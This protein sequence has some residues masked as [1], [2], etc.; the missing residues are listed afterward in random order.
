LAIELHILGS[1]SAAFAHNRH[2]TSQLLRIQEKYFL[3]DCGE[4]TQ[5]LLK[6]YKIKLSRI[7]FILIS[8]LHGDHYY[9]LIGLLSTIHLYGRTTELKIIGPPGL[10]DI[11]SLQLKYSET[12]LNY[13]I[14]FVEWVP[15]QEQVVYE[16]EKLTIETVP[17]DHR[18]P[19]SG[20]LFKEKPKR[21]GLNR[22]QIQRHL[23]PVQINNLKDGK[24]LFDE[25][26]NLLLKNTEVTFPAKR[27]FS[28]AYCSDT[29]YKPELAHKLKGVD[30]VYHEATFMD[31]MKERAENTYH[32]TARQAAQFA[33]DAE[34][35]HLLLG[36]FSTRYKDLSPML[37]EAKDLFENTSLAIEGEK[38]LVS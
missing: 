32:S 3:I 35:G 23:T 21:R 6:K 10:S 28:Y 34:I 33:K 22:K 7:N 17:L 15:N 24:D 2:Q 37:E 19:C 26:G 14:D 13:P 36:H 5:L 1:N 11:L 31:D 16:D 8:H 12:R 20:Y 25:D 27:P 38:F 29:K 9:G 30:M 18:V 4:G